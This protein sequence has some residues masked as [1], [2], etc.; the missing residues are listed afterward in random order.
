MSLRDS[1]RAAVA[2]KV[3]SCAPYQT[4][5][6][7]SS[8]HRATARATGPQLSGV[9]RGESSTA[10]ATEDSR[11]A[12]H[13]RCAAVAPVSEARVV[14]ITC[15]NARGERC[16]AHPR[17]G[18]PAGYI[19]GITDLPQSCPTWSARVGPHSA[20]N[21]KNAMSL[22]EAAQPGDARIWEVVDYMLEVAK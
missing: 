11:A 16:A 18:L 3:A 19:G 2:G 10:C 7:T 14:C 22:R 12:Q 20:S 5:H 21:G 6:A 1:L 13:V 15:R 17:S 8:M 4:Q 9:I